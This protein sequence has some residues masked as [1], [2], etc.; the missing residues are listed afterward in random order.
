MLYVAKYSGPFGYLK[1]WTAVRDSETFSQQFLTPS[2][3]EGIEKKLFPELLEQSGIFKI[4]RYRLTYSGLSKQQEQTQPRGIKQKQVKKNN[5]RSIEIS[6]PRSILIRGVLVN[7]ILFLCFD[8]EEDALKAVSQH[9]C[10]C[11]NE[12]ILMPDPEIIKVTEDE[13]DDPKGIFRGFELR[14]G[15]NENSFVVGFNRFNNN[16]PMYGWLH[17]VGENPLRSDIEEI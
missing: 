5:L 14:F 17:I 3:I 7:P 12:D 4:K 13:F 11:R 9:I 10:L 2:V 1:P 15:K 8:S 16:E 6:R